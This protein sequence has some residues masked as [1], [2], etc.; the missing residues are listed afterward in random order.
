MQKIDELR[1]E[2]PAR[3][4]LLFEQG[5]K[6]LSLAKSGSVSRFQAAV[7]AVKQ[8]DML[9]FFARRIF[10]T[11]LLGGHYMLAQVMLD[12]GFAVSL[13]GLPS[14]PLH[15][16]LQ[17]TEDDSSAAAVAEFLVARAKLDVNSPAEQSWETPAGSWPAHADTATVLRSLLG[18]CLLTWPGWLAVRPG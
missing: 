13:P 7:A 10:M 12:N 5:E 3:C 4:K 8:E 11:A 18:S 15:D 1:K 14:T 9:L 2:D 17:V 6:L 16:I